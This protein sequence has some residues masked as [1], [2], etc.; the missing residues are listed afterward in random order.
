MEIIKEE[1]PDLGHLQRFAKLLDS[2]IRI[3]G[4][5]KTIGIDPIIGL[6]PFI[7]DMVT[8]VFSALLIFQTLKSK[9]SPMLVTKMFMNITLD[10]VVGAIPI[11]GSI[12]DFIYKANERN[13]RLLVEYKSSDKHRESVLPYFLGMLIFSILLVFIA[14]WLSYA[15]FSYLF[16]LL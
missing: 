16:D 6:V 1:S 2:S 12:F 13:Y 9:P 7:G 15:L 5:N 8:Y 14:L 3:P 11:L 4:T 10:A